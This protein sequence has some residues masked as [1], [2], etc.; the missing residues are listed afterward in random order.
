[1]GWG[2]DYSP[3]FIL[4]QHSKYI[5]YMI[6][7]G[8]LDVAHPL[9]QPYSSGELLDSLKG[10]DDSVTGH[11][12]GLLRKDLEV[13]R[14]KEGKGNLLL[15]ADAGGRVN[16]V[17]DGKLGA[18]GFGG[19]YAGYGYKNFG[20]FHNFKIDQAYGNDTSA[21]GTNGKLNNPNIGRSNAAYAQVDFKGMNVFVGRMRR[22]FGV[23]GEQGLMLSD[24]AH[25]FDHFA[26]TF[27][28]KALKFTTMFGRLDDLYGYD[29]R[30]T[31]ANYKWNK[32]YFSAHRFEIAV[33]KN[34]EFVFSESVVYGGADGT[35]SGRINILDIAQIK[36][37]ASDTFITKK[38]KLCFKI[39]GYQGSG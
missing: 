19:I 28:N 1:M 29:I 23:M 16:K 34:L 37:E 22:N 5:D 27:T 33:L 39:R 8:R 11:W 2:Q 18:E 13:L 10:L 36:D 12:T 15:G 3:Y 26:F 32:R 38:Y 25:S 31:V 30:D 17:N 14:G 24:N 21:F 35:Q 4:E 6:N 20:L 7:S 9:N